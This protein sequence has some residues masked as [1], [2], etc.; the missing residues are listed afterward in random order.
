V[1]RATPPINALYSGTGLQ[2]PSKPGDTH[3]LVTYVDLGHWLDRCLGPLVGSR[4]LGTRALEVAVTENSSDS[5]S[6]AG[7][8][9]K[10]LRELG[11]PAIAEHSQRFFKTAKGEYGYGDKFLGIRVP[12]LRKHV[13]LWQDIRLEQ[14]ATLLKSGFHEERLLALLLLVRQF[15]SGDDDHKTAIYNLYLNH[16]RYIN[17]WD[18]VDSSAHLILGP[19]LERRDRQLLYELSDSANFWERRMAIMATFHFIK[20]EEFE[21]ALKI[22]AR[23]LR[24]DEDLIHKAV[25]WMLREVG[26]RNLVVEKAFLKAH[27]SQMPRTML[28]YAI[29]KFP[30]KERKAYREGK[31]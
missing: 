4:D 7:Q 12:V 26:K 19:Y 5:E 11:D 13:K 23:L 9:S 21:D 10:V 16:T 22:A 29:E 18:L 15:S 31:V 6:T 20:Q 28:R 25:G 3:T 2:P 30:D 1:L 27:Y 17:N 8:I 14:V 24:D